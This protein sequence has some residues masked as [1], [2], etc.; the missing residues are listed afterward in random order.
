MS[1]LD[2]VEKMKF[3]DCLRAILYQSHGEAE[4]E[5]YAYYQKNCRFMLKVDASVVHHNPHYYYVHLAL[6][7]FESLCKTHKEISLFEVISNQTSEEVIPL[8]WSH[9]FG[10]RQEFYE[11]EGRRFNA[12]HK[13]MSIL[14]SS[15]NFMDYCIKDKNESMFAYNFVRNPFTIKVDCIYRKMRQENYVLAETTTVKEFCRDIVDSIYPTLSTHEK[16]FIWKLL[17]H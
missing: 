5:T 7:T 8:T 1:A 4:S 13:P 2:S 9:F 16:N 3:T 12:K 15:T 11:N 10:K 14:Y 6:W 17:K